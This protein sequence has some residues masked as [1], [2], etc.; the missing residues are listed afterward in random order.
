M[1]SCCFNRI[2]AHQLESKQHAV[3]SRCRTAATGAWRVR[4]WHV[5]LI[6]SNLKNAG[7]GDNSMDRDWFFWY[8]SEVVVDC[9]VLRNHSLVWAVIVLSVTITALGC[10]VKKPSG[11]LSGIGLEAETR[12][13][14]YCNVFFFCQF[15]F[16]L[17]RCRLADVEAYTYAKR[18]R[19][20]RLSI[21]NTEFPHAVVGGQADGFNVIY[22]VVAFDG[23]RDRHRKGFDE[24][25]QIEL[26]IY[27]HHAKRLVSCSC[28]EE[29]VK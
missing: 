13:W 10:F 26:V 11:S 15:K 29:G 1:L 2:A 23:I 24:S 14:K 4:L 21:R 19:H 3:I 17:C 8:S 20:E 25:P 22:C 28:K 12:D 6:A 16:E 18:M 27:Q 5:P 7:D 9:V